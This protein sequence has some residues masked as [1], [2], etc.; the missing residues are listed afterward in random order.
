MAFFRFVV[1]VLIPLA[2]ITSGQAQDTLRH[3]D[4]V[5]LT[6]KVTVIKGSR[7][8]FSKADE[9]DVTYVINTADLSSIRYENGR[10][11]TFAPAAVPAGIAVNRGR[12]ILAWRPTDLVLTDFTMTYE[13]LSRSRKVSWRIPLSVGIDRI[14]EQGNRTFRSTY[15]RNKVFLTGLD[16]NFYLGKPD[17]FR[18]FMGPSF[19]VGFYRAPLFDPFTLRTESQA[20]QRFTLVFNNGLWYQASRTILLGGEFGLGVFRNR[21]TTNQYYFYE[22]RGG[23]L[24]TGSLNLGI[25]F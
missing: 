3:T 22:N 20:G 21:V 6:G 25:Q 17:R 8:E 15:I 23:P 10:Q 13:R 11:E 12:N 4:G 16:L 9:P 18:Y 2:G 1:L 24:L 5:L 19:R 14:T 7:V